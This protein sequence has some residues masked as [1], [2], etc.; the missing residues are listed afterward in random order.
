MELAEKKYQ[1]EE[2]D[3]EI[4]VIRGEIWDNCR[5]WCYK[6]D[7]VVP[8]NE[9]ERVVIR[10]PK[11]KRLMGFIP[12]AGIE[13]YL[14]TLDEDEREARE[15]GVWHHLSG[16]VYKTLDRAVHVYNDFPIPQSWMKVEALDPHDAR[17]SC[18]LFG[19]VSPEE[20]EIFGKVRHR[21]YFFDYIFLDSSIEELARQVKATR[22][23]HGYKDPSMVILDRKWGTKEQAKSAIA[24]G[25]SRTWQGELERYGIRRIRHSQSGPGDV[26][27]GH[28]I[29]REYLK[30]HYS[31]VS[32]DAKP[33]MLFAKKGCGGV[34]SPIQYMFNYQYD[35]DSGKPI[36]TYKDW[37]DCAR[38]VAL[39]QPVYRAPEEE[40]NTVDH[41]KENYERAV[42][43]R[44]R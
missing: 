19:A 13:E 36:E 12:R 23:L 11:C 20:I 3:Q 9:I 38:Y 2:L 17:Q 43:I 27:L 25:E 44:R 6:C 1:D 8:E 4:A 21:I 7:L 16:L 10:C 22:A 32:Q 39:E 28:K 15:K 29:V 5:D 34:K 33:G 31:K 30:L 26:E 42:K 18:W 24:E 41:L 37:P 14:K 35:A 40:A